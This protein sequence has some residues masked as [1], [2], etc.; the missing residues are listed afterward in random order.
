MKTK[1]K[2]TAHARAKIKQRN[3]SKRD[4]ENVVTKPDIIEK[5]KF[6]DTLTHFIG[7]AKDRYLRVIGRKEAKEELLVISCFFD[8]RL[9]RRR[10]KDAKT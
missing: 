1:L 6:D 10:S 7:R 4:I 3:I 9:K 8:R 2:F 5:D